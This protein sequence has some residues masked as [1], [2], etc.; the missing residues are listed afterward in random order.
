[1]FDIALDVCLP[2]HS[3]QL[4]FFGSDLPHKPTRS[5][6]IPTVMEL[7]GGTLYIIMSKDP[8]PL[9]AAT[10]HCPDRSAISISSKD[11]PFVSMTFFLTNITAIMHM[12]AKKEYK[13]WAPKRF[14]NSR[15]NKPTKQLTTQCTHIQKAIAF[16]RIRLENISGSSSAGTGPAPIANMN[17]NN[18]VPP[19]ERKTFPVA[20]PIRLAPAT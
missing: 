18:N 10:D 9:I 12:N 7:N 19:T 4:Q 1:M 8:N 3:H 6:R 15:N 17:T 13:T 16:A 5:K 14:R 20:D 2:P 11:L